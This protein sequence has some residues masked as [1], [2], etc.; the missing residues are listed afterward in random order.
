MVPVNERE[1]LEIGERN[2]QWFAQNYPELQKQH[3]DKFVAVDAGK[4]VAT[5]GSLDYLLKVIEGRADMQTV[6]IEFVP[7]KD[8]VFVI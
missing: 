3:A 4:L 5:H 1:L 2:L 7:S 8:R 6:L